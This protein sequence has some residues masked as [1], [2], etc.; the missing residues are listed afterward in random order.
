MLTE[1]APEMVAAFK[2]EGLAANTLHTGGGVMVL[3]IALGEGREVWLSRDTNW[4]VGFYDFKADGEDEG[5]FY[6]LLLFGEDNDDAAKVAAAV[7]GT[8]RRM[9]VQ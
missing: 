5:I 2:A 3:T 7:A 6:D 1:T 8:L 4:I 9:G